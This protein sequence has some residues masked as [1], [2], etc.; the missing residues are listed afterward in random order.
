MRFQ[1]N[2]VCTSDSDDAGSR[3]QEAGG[4]MHLL[5]TF[6]PP[7]SS[8]LPPALK[9]SLLHLVNRVIRRPC[10]KSHIQNR[11]TLISS[12][13]HARAVGYKNIFTMMQLVPFVK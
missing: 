6:E 5:Y 11:R 12:A 4:R 10:R 2:L 13:R 8:L 1:C 3:K 9:I 7:A